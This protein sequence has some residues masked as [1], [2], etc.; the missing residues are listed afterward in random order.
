M[1]HNL[2][3]FESTRTRKNGNGDSAVVAELKGTTQSSRNLILL[4]SFFYLISVI[5]LILTEIGNIKNKP[6]LRS[7]YFLKISLADIL[8]STS[9]SDAILVNSIARSLGLH[10]FYQVG[11]WNFC[12]GYDDEGITHCSKPQNL[13]WFNPVQIILNEL[14]AGATVALPAE[15]TTILTLIRIVSKLMFG[16]FMLSLCMNFLCMFF[17]P[18]VL[19]SRFYSFH[20]VTLTFIS[21]LLCTAGSVIATVMYAV[22]KRVIGSQKELNISASLGAQMFAFMWIASTFSAAG[23]IVHF[24]LA[25][26]SRREQ[27]K[28]KQAQVV[29][30]NREGLGDEKKTGVRRRVLPR[31]WKNRRAGEVI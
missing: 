27:K 13:W 16:F 24:H 30:E 28:E 1:T 8:P 18:I 31:F 7:S 2:P 11:L 12:E 10:D 22:F 4:S 25:C 21:S 26:V 23:W 29:V 6:V 14:L 3:M 5:F 9:A 20:F 19:Y 15:I 17:G